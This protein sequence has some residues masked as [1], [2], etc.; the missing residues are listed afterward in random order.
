MQKLVI[1][2]RK[3]KIQAE[4]IENLN[5]RLLNDSIIIRNDSI[6]IENKTREIERKAVQIDE[7]NA[8]I[9]KEKVKSVIWKVSSG[10]LG[11]VCIRLIF[12]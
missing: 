9:K 7:L 12:K 11:L 3:S 6:I 2:A 4:Q 10:I 1:D 5:Q 8:T